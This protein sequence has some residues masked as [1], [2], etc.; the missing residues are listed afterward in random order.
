MNKE[1]YPNVSF[2]TCQQ[3]TKTPCRVPHVKDILENDTYHNLS[4]C[5]TVWDFNCQKWIIT[6]SSQA[7]N[8]CIRPCYNIN[9]K[10]IPQSG[11]RVDRALVLF[12]SIIKHHV[13][14]SLVFVL[15]WCPG[16]PEERSWQLR[17]T[18]PAGQRTGPP[19]QDEGGSQ[20][21]RQSPRHKSLHG[22]GSNPRLNQPQPKTARRWRQYHT[23]LPFY[24]APYLFYH[25]TK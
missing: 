24:F 5:S 23:Y 14:V 4:K 2:S 7:I 13:F 17:K 25:C 12:L 20:R 18:P 22:H 11:L 15:N 1:S 21:F 10:V 3:S 8:K 16:Q 9:Y 19:D 6:L